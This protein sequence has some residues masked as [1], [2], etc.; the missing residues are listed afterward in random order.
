MMRAD[1][2][3]IGKTIVS[4]TEVH[5]MPNGCVVPVLRLNFSDGTSAS[6]VMEYDGYQDSYPALRMEKK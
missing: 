3:V 6:V 4:V 5:E 2:D 1:Q